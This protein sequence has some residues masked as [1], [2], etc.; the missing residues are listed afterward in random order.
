MKVYQEL[1]QLFQA[2]GVEDVFGL[3]GDANLFWMSEM[4][5]RPGVSVFHTRHEHC[6]VGMAVGY[7]RAT[8]KVG[9]ASVTCGPG[10]TQ[11]QTILTSA[12][13]ARIPLVVF[14]GEAPLTAKG[15]EQAMDQAPL[16]TACGARYIAI[17]SPQ[18]VQHNICEAFF[19]AKTRRQPV[20][21]GLPMDIQQMPAA[22]AP[23]D[24]VPS[25]AFI[26]RL[27][28][29]LASPGQIEAL[30][31]DLHAASRPV[32]L[33]GAG[34]VAAGSAAALTRLAAKSDAVLANTLLARGVF[35]DDPFSLTVI[36]GFA[37]IEAEDY[38]KEADL[39]V[40]F[41][42]SMSVHTTNWGNM[43]P[44]ARIVQI[45]TDPV[46]RVGGLKVADHYIRGDCGAAASAL[47]DAF[48]VLGDKPLRNR[49]P[50]LGQTLAGARTR[51]DPYDIEPGTVDP[52]LAFNALESVIPGDYHAISGSAHQAYWHSKMRGGDPTRYH[53]VRAFSAIGNALPI[54]AGVAA[55]QGDGRVV[56][57]EGDGSLMMHIQE[58]ETLARHGI[59]ML[60]V[61][62]NDGGFGGE[63]HMLRAKGI[64]PDHVMF[65]RPDFEAIA[66]AFGIRGRTIS[67][68]E[69]IPASIAEYEGH[70]HA[71]IWDLHI[72]HNVMSPRK[73]RQVTAL[74]SK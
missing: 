10:F 25:E 20:V 55:A 65:G 4:A 33:A 42:A 8:G 26:P 40:A 59:K 24:Y 34:A 61:C 5:E 49:T 7:H 48:G 30:A 72:S 73:Q 70:P 29:I 52:R 19:Q 6:A 2:E 69:D 27:E 63:A 12:V 64:D 37:S 60:I 74:M 54:A 35:D 45:D 11:I 36:G 32:V 53:A 16:A 38:L 50:E 18:A 22:S 3:M 46:G 66:R 43:F 17:H 62:S 13:R 15:F 41:G 58:F 44:R 28:P 57:Y 1:V 71:E 9:V 31:R 67:R 47:L 21:V 68:L 51:L 14:A 56:L 39:V 23:E